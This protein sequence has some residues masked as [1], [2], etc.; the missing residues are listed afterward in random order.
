MYAHVMDAIMFRYLISL[1]ISEE[2]E[3][4][5]MNVVT[6]YIYELLN[7]DIYMRIPD[8][9]KTQRNVFDQITKIII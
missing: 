8:K 9:F 7:S 4:R 2:L 3:I 5:L 6:A 1:I